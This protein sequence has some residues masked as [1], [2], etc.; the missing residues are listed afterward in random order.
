MLHNYSRTAWAWLQTMIPPYDHVL[1]ALV[2]PVTRDPSWPCFFVEIVYDDTN[3]IM[4]IL[5]HNYQHI[6]VTQKIIQVVMP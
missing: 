3:I 5:V 4:M 6:M 1:L 2:I